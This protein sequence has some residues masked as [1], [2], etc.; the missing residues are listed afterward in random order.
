MHAQNP[1]MLIE[2]TFERIHSERMADLP[3]LNPRISVAAVGFARQGDDWRGVLVTPWGI[4]LLLLPAVAHWP[5]PPPLER[6]FRHYPAGTFAFLPNHEEELGDYLACP[7]I[8][9]MKPFADQATALA[10]AQACLIALD[11]PPAAQTAEVAVPV[12]DARRRFLGLGG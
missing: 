3:F 8:S 4:Q 1:S 6:A 7:L 5:V 9:D 10:T 2:Q 11:T 12:S